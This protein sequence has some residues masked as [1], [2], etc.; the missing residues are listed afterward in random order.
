V[1]FLKSLGIFM[2]QARR[3]K[4]LAKTENTLTRL[5][6]LKLKLTQALILKSKLIQ[7]IKEGDVKL[8]DAIF[9]TKQSETDGETL[10]FKLP[11]M[12]Q[13]IILAPDAS[14]NTPLK[15][16]LILSPRPQRKDIV[17]ILLEKAKV[18]PTSADHH[19]QTSMHIVAKQD[20]LPIMRLLL[21][22]GAKLEAFDLHKKISPFMTAIYHKKFQTAKFLFK[23]TH[24]K[25][26]LYELHAK[27]ESTVN[28]LI[29]INH[30]TLAN[31]MKEFLGVL[32][33]RQELLQELTKLAKTGSVDKFRETIQQYSVTYI[34]WLVQK[35]Q[36]VLL[37][38]AILNYKNPE[39]LDLLLD[40]GANPNVPLDNEYWNKPLH[41]VLLK[42]PEE[43]QE[44]LIEILLTYKADVNGQNRNGF[45][46]LAL[47]SRHDSINI[48]ELLTKHG[49]NLNMPEFIQGNSPL[50]LA[51]ESGHIRT[52]QFLLNKPMVNVN[53]QNKLNRIPLHTA[54]YGK[55]Y[56]L[57]ELLL[58][59]KDTDIYGIKSTSGHY[60]D[61]LIR[62]LAVSENQPN[63]LKTL[64]NFQ[65]SLIDW[66]AAN[67]PTVSTATQTSVRA[68]TNST[69]PSSASASASASLT[70]FSSLLKSNT[71]TSG[72]NV[73]TSLAS[74]NPSMIS[75]AS[76]H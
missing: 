58:K 76:K 1:I 16:S 72:A 67:H 24:S 70:L 52:T 25:L 12:C 51:V 54:G 14:G 5:L 40:Y 66:H 26:S 34:K 61:P 33:L 43:F 71:S 68:S 64:N 53:A 37:C 59:R 45:T 62:R 27:A 41:Q 55:R 22:Y 28:G 9:S 20:D 21:K 8:I 35:G 31:H 47:A 10:F 56:E 23:T 7:A 75:T 19:H 2:T 18:D 63:L 74:S 39:L 3:E 6:I 65:S 38:N 57:I 30:K 36:H 32:N 46:P 69:S 11:K 4:P 13:Q 44:K 17:S 60:C 15:Q 48:V 50:H 29:S 42:V 49:A 73:T